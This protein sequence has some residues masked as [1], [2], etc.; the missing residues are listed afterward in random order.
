MASNRRES[1][2]SKQNSK[3]FLHSRERPIARTKLPIVVSDSISISESPEEW[4]HHQ[5]PLSKRARDQM[6]TRARSAKNSAIYKPFSSPGIDAPVHLMRLGIYNCNCRHPISTMNEHGHYQVTGCN[7]CDCCYY[8]GRR[9]NYNMYEEDDIY[10]NT[11]DDDCCY[12]GKEIDPMSHKYCDMYC[13]D[14]IFEDDK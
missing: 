12:A 9:Y 13:H 2:I 1:R 5:V 10:N 7:N 3:F 4:E 11:Y 8:A 6:I 14:M